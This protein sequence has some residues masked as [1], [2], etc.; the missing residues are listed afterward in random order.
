MYDN[1]DEPELMID[2]E[3]VIK[4]ESVEEILDEEIQEEN[5]T[6]ESTTIEPEPVVPLVQEEQSE[7]P[8][9][10]QR[11]DELIFKDKNELLDYIKSNLTIEEILDKLTYVEE[12]GAIKRKEILDK[13]TERV[14]FRDMFE[15]YLFQGQ[16]T[17]PD[18]TRL[19]PKQSSLIT[20]FVGNVSKIMAC[21]NVVKYK[22]LDI[23]SEKHP[24]EFLDHALQVTIIF[25]FF[26]LS[27]ESRLGKN[28]PRSRNFL[29]NLYKLA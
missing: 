21:N 17:N 13:I 26:I 20:E 23:L 11:S 16:K 5:S 25:G 19:N 24:E 29:L 3:I 27:I 4:V 12:P 14:P 1:E 15:H 10:N 6:V 9:T 8:E 7:A 28:W 2:S 18:L 22:I